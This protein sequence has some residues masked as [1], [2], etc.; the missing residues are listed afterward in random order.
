MLRATGFG[1]PIRRRSSRWSR[2]R[3]PKTSFRTSPIRLAANLAVVGLVLANM[4]VA[5]RL[6]GEEDSSVAVV[7]GKAQQHGEG[8][9]F[10]RLREALDNLSRDEIGAPIL[11]NGGT[12]EAPPSYMAQLST[13][14]TV[15]KSVVAGSDSSSNS[16]G[17]GSS[18][19]GSDSEG[20]DSEGDDS[21]GDDSE[22]DDNE[23]DDSE[24][25]DSEGSD[26][27]SDEGDEDEGDDSEGSDEGSDEGDEDEGDDSEGD[28][29]EGDD[30]EGSDEGSD[31]GDE[32]EGSDE[33]SNEGDENEGDDGATISPSERAVG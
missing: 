17:S 5:Y 15:S 26:E 22:G 11:I 16:S 20:D 1:S 31:E 30:S 18:G 12:S 9:A 33:S 6:L 19:S 32:D 14:L 21:E 2:P 7:L 8:S 10:E 24:G 25:D 23:G 29:D 4:I 13:P 27:S 28:E 3:Q